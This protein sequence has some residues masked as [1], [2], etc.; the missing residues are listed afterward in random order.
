M[1]LINYPDHLL[2][3]LDPMRTEWLFG[4]LSHLEP[5]LHRDTAA[6]V[7]SLYLRCSQLRQELLAGFEIDDYYLAEL[8]VLI[9]ITGNYYG[10]GEEYSN[11]PR[12]LDADNH[13]VQPTSEDVEIENE[14]KSFTENE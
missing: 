9:S 5:P 11:F 13:T 10:Q 2:R 3:K 8:N 1:Y 6:S 4:L 12:H 7:R 14:S